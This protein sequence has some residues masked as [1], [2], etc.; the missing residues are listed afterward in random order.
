MS[1]VFKILDCFNSMFQLGTW[2]PSRL[3]FLVILPKDQVPSDPITVN[4]LVKNVLDLEKLGIIYNQD[5]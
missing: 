1:P 2:L 4:M 3:L 5:K